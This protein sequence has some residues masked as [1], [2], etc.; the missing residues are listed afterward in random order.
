MKAWLCGVGIDHHWPSDRVLTMCRKESRRPLISYCPSLPMGGMVL[1]LIVEPRL[2]SCR[3]K[4]N[5]HIKHI[6]FIIDL[7]IILFF[8]T[9]FDTCLES[10]SDSKLVWLAVDIPVTCDKQSV[11]TWSRHKYFLF[12]LIYDKKKSEFTCLVWILQAVT[13]THVHSSACND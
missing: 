4:Y 8:Y 1:Q 10:W 11:H 6:C 2:C 3:R 13:S 9:V 5:T 12:L 7:G